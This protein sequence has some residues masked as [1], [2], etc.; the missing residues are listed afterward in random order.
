M[1]QTKTKSRISN[2]HSRKCLICQHPDRRLID[3][4]YLH[5]RS[6]SDITRQYSL[7]H[8]CAVYRHAQATGLTARRRSNVFSVLDSIVEQA[9]TVRP[10]AGD[11]IKAVRLLSQLSGQWKEPERAC[12][13]TQQVAADRSPN[14]DTPE[15]AVVPTSVHS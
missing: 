9:E 7:G 3:S 11:V 8:R 4:D 14:R 12:I 2:R 10:S 6:P 13:V 5:W 15:Q 1:Q